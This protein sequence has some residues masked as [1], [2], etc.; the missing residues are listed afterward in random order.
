MPVAGA[1]VAV[2][3]AG[4]LAELLRRMRLVI[5][6]GVAAGTKAAA[7]ARRVN[8]GLEI[9]L[10][11]DEAEV[12]Y[13]G[14][15]QPYYLGGV[16][17]GRDPLIIRRPAE[18]AAA[19]ITVRT[20]HRVTELDLEE[21]TVRVHDRVRDRH[22]TLGYDRL[23]LA[24]GARP[25][26]PQMPGIEAD[27]VVSL[28]SIAELDRFDSALQRLRPGSAVIVGG[29]YVGLEVAEALRR[30]GLA[31]T[32]LERMERLLPRF[33]PELSARLQRVLRD[34]GVELR[35]GEHLAGLAA[36]G[37]RVR[38][39]WTES[40][41]RLP[42][43]LVVLALGIRPNV[44]LATAAGIRLG[45]SGA[46]AVNPAQET[47]AAG[48]Y[49]AGDCAESH[50][51]IAGVPVWNPLGD[52]ANLQGRV[53]GENAAGGHAEFPGVLGTAIFKAFD[54]KVGVTGLA[55]GAARVAGY[56]PIT[57]VIETRD[58]AR[59]YPGGRPVWLKLIAAAGDGRLLGAECFGSG[60]V[61][62]LT[63]IIATA[64]LG[65]LS[66]RDL[67]HADFAYAPPFSPVLSPVIL[68]AQRLCQNLP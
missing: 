28:R 24:T 15:G 32:L 20:Q 22:E 3:R 33:D 45:A 52:I 61:D 6:G 16:I 54:C 2:R 41:L 63:D 47:S 62:K 23:I 51:R 11:Q 46:I 55:E 1:D 13:T 17:A 35:L 19:G 57:A 7:R 44:S 42:A 60:A 31:V 66:C 8:P 25:L 64:L 26:I 18:F 65:G 36:E 12:S 58:K 53:A 50:H 48:V 5:V 43:D 49:A 34:A 21:R 30:R 10:F 37:G 9:V 67:E 38:A 68:A 4:R 56:R 40:G 39:V 27:G 29:G 59:Y 14:C